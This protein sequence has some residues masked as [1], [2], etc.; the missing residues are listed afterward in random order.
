MRIDFPS[1]GNNSD[2]ISEASFD[3]IKKLLNPNYEER[4]GAN[5]A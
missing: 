2:E 3:I 4:L 1:I 5:G